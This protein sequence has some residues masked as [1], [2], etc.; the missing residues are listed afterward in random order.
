MEHLSDP[1]VAGDI[2]KRIGQFQAGSHPLW[3]KMNVLQM[4]AHCQVPL[5]VALNE[6]L[7]HHLKQFGN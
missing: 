5:S 4:L 2:I 6:H 7:D 3:G 1:A